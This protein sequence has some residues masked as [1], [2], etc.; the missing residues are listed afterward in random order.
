M[1]LNANNG[2]DKIAIIICSYQQA[3]P[4][5]YNRP[6]PYQKKFGLKLNYQKPNPGFQGPPQQ[7]MS[8]GPNWA[9]NQEN[10][11]NKKK[12]K[13]LLMEQVKT[14]QANQ[15]NKSDK[16]D[17]GK[18]KVKVANLANRIGQVSLAKRLE[19]TESYNER[20]FVSK[21]PKVIIP[22]TITE[23]R[24]MQKWFH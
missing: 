3:G 16:K 15:T 21:D 19:T 24:K 17:K 5:S 13:Q 18:G 12:A 2:K 4:S 11:Q 20:V 1:V 9:R 6:A 10:R 7:N 23:Y 8:K 22:S 14:L